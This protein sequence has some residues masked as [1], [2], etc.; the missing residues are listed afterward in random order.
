M[1]DLAA[2]S[3]GC[4]R[5][6]L[7]A[8]PPFAGHRIERVL[9]RGRHSIVYLAARPASC[10]GGRVALKV[11]RGMRQPGS[12]GADLQ[13]EFAAMAALAHPRVIEAFDRGLAGG[14]AWLAMAY[15]EGGNLDA[16]RRRG[17]RAIGA[18][19][20]M[21]QAASALAWT[22]ANGWVHRDVKPANLFLR[23]DGAI[24]LGD[25]GSACRRDAAGPPSAGAAAGTPRYAPPEQTGGAPADPAA[26]VYGLGACL[27]ELLTGRPLFAG[28]T[29]DEL[30]GQHLMAPIPRL[31]QELAGWQPLLDAMLA[32]DPS[33]RPPDG[34]AV[35]SLLER[36][37]PSLSWQSGGSPHAS[38]NPP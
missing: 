19:E 26:D 23:K 30:L 34:Q 15:A 25:F 36:A 9:G 22:H 16:W 17:G 2:V 12:G 13:E 11:A 35:L 5:E 20:L 1:S 27:Y 18:F 3:Q 14:V 4:F 29:S 24:A 21:H 6:A 37:R 38:R 7:A 10:G 31:A 32:K 28:E 8:R 33:R